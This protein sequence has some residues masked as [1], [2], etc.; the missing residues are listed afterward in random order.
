ML[1]YPDGL[2]EDQVRGVMQDIVKGVQSNARVNPAH[3][4]TT[5]P[6]DHAS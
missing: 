3:D 6:T 5:F 2:P 4:R 1:G